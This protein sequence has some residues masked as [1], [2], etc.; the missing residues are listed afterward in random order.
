MKKAIL[1]VSFGTSHLDAL[2]NSIEKIERKIENTFKDYVVKRAFTAHMI[3]RKLNKKH[4]IKVM[5]PEE[6]MESLLED[7]I[8]ELI[9]QPLHMIPGEEYQYVK[10]VINKYEDRFKNIK[11][12][13]PIFYYQGIDELPQDYSS[14]IKSI[15]ELLKD[16][17]ATILFG[18]GSANPSNAVYGCLQVVLEDEGYNNVYVGTVEGYPNF[19]SVLKRMKKDNLK[20]VTLIPLMVVAGDHAKNDMASD[21][22]DSW[23]SMLE[24]EGIKAIPYLKGLG[25]LDKFN[26]LYIDRINDVIENKY[27]GAGETKKA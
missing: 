8:E 2:E 13:R 12:G 24:R 4:G 7:G 15:E 6:A 17:K 3:I 26:Q 11:V 23:K 9:V 18:H 22:E 20:E 1:V 21:E 27:I 10:N 14:F 19:Y 16:Q 5:T 25:E